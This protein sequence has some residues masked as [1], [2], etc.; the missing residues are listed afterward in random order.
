M[1]VYVDEMMIMVVTAH[2]VKLLFF[3][4]IWWSFRSYA[5]VAEFFS[6]T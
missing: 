3:T 5:Y 6:G 4:V 1:L 2:D